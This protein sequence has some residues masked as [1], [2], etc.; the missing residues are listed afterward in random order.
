MLTLAKEFAKT[1]I[2][3]EHA[4]IPHDVAV[5]L[6]FSTIAAAL[7]HAG[8]RITTLDDSK[9]ADG[10]KWCLARDWLE[11]SIRQLLMKAE[12]EIAG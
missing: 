5:V 7:C 9:L 4:A 1:H 3:S 11:P 8:V 12:K 2:H 10:L 6:Y